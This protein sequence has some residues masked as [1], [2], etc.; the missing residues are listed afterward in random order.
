MSWVRSAIVFSSVPSWRSW[1]LVQTTRNGRTTR[2]ELVRIA[3]SHHPRPCS[4][5]WLKASWPCVR[6]A[7]NS[8]F[9]SVSVS[10]M[11]ARPLFSER[12]PRDMHQ[13]RQWPACQK[14]AHSAPASVVG[15]SFGPFV[16]FPCHRCR[17]DAAIARQHCCRRRPSEFGK[18]ATALVQAHQQLSGLVVVVAQNRSI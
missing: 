6:A 18:L 10:T 15:Q 3:T 9:V 11:Y 14:P 13:H 1:Y 16:S 12:S 8:C 2:L 5:S 7:S 4:F 17:L